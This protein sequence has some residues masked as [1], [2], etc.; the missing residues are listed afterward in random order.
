LKEKFEA[1]PKTTSSGTKV[2]LN[3]SRLFLQLVQTIPKMV[4]LLLMTP[5]LLHFTFTILKVI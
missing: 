5:Q 2:V 1:D 4:V 3:M